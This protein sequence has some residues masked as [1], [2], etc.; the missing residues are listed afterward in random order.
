M[1]LAACFVAAL[2]AL[3]TGRPGAATITVTSLLDDNVGCT[4]RNAV[5]SSSEGA[6]I[7]GCAAGGASNTIVFASSGTIALNG[8]ALN[9]YRN[10]L[11][12]AGNGVAATII[13]AQNIDRA[14]DN[15]DPVSPTAIS[16]AWQNLT[17]K[18]GNATGAGAGGF[19][20]AGALYVD[21]LTTATLS[22]CALGSNQAQSSGGAIENR[23][24]L[25]ISA[26]A[27]DSNSAAGQ[28]GAIRNIGKLTISGSTFSGNTANSGGAIWHSTGAAAQALTVSNSTFAG[29]TSATVGGAVAADDSGSVGPVSLT[30]VT[31]TGNVAS[32]AGGGI[33]MDNGATFAIDRTVLALNTAGTGADCAVGAGKTVTSPGYNVFGSLAGCS[34]IGPAT[35]DVVAS[36]S[37]GGLAS[38]GGPTQTVALLAGSVGVDIAPCTTSVDQRGLARPFGAACDAGAFELQ[39]APP[40]GPLVFRTYVSRDGSDANPCTLQAPCRLL[41][42]AL[43]KVKDG[44]E[45]WMVDSGNFNVGV[46]DIVKSVTIQTVPGAYGSVVANNAGAIRVNAAGVEVTLRGI[47]VLNLAGG[48]NTG[49]NFVQGAQLTV[50]DTQVFGLANGIVATAPNA[51]LAVSGC[52][53]RDNTFG[54]VVQ[55]TLRTAIDASAFFANITWA[56]TGQDGAQV[57]I[58][59]SVISGSS[60]GAWIGAANGA[61]S[62]LAISASELSGNGVGVRVSSGAP[63]DLSEVV[64]DDVSF[65]YNTTGVE[66]FGAGPK[67]AFSRL[68]NTFRFNGTNLGGAV[69]TP[70]TP[71]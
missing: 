23:G 44:G 47:A 15:L 13:D 45:V 60:M 42:A 6:G 57:R 14:F 70:L 11:T 55:G 9:I 69:L 48:S 71:K 8:A 5:R 68:N 59:N 61:S 3:A 21:T 67:N 41:P 33:Y 19:S 58:S 28:G 10:S 12:I 39:P 29:N 30:H 46:V 50:E 64:L 26:C 40:P 32:G 18:R 63:G 66:F 54:M 56:V 43:A 31:I 53:I 1:R 52:T 38:N 2:L 25:V 62:Q 65:T 7:G 24:T 27:F 36:P 17:I 4:L 35:G 51:V 37:L 20:S 16:I 49:I 34:V 22:N